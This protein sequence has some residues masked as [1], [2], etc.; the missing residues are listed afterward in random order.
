MCGGGGSRVVIILKIAF[1]NSLRR[2]LITCLIGFSAQKYS[3]FIVVK[4][5]IGSSLIR[6][7]YRKIVHKFSDNIVLVALVGWRYLIRH[8]L[9][10]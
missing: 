5:L 6:K 2:D 8:H 3:I 9:W 7:K 10:G 1:K 4:L